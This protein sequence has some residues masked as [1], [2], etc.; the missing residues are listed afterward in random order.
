M[1]AITLS[2]FVALGAA[3]PAA[4]MTSPQIE[5]VETKN[6]SPSDIHSASAQA[7]FDRIKAE[8]ASDE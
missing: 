6:V 4:A 3:L 5:V 2:L 8:S 7:I 1:K